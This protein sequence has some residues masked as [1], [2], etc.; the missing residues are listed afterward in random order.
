MIDVQGMIEKMKN[1]RHYSCP[2][3]VLV[4]YLHD[5]IIAGIAFQTKF[6]AADTGDVIDLSDC[7]VLKEY[8]WVNVSNEIQDGN[9]ERSIK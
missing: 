7:E 2:T 5:E 3:Q 4:D 9:I 6:I 8:E 1:V